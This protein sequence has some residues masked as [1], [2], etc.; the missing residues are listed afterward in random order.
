MAKGSRVD[1]DPLIYTISEEGRLHFFVSRRVKR[2]FDRDVVGNE[3]DA[4]AVW[5]GFSGEEFIK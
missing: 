2:Q 4:D 3:V 1:I 5:K